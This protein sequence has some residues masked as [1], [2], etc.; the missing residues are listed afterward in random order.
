MN[1]IHLDVYSHD[2]V[3]FN[4]AYDRLISKLPMMKDT[5]GYNVFTI[6]GC[7]PGVGATAI[8]INISVSLA[9][10]N[11]KT[12]LVDADMRKSHSMKRLSSDADIGLSDFL[13]GKASFDDVICLT[14]IDN[15]HFMSSGEFSENPVTLL[16]SERFQEVIRLIGEQYAYVIFDSPALNTTVD[17]SI[18]APKTSG[19]VLVAEYKKTRISKIRS[20]KEE[21]SQGGANVI[22]I[23]L[24]NVAKKDYKRY[25]ENYDYFSKEKFSHQKKAEQKKRQIK[26]SNACDWFK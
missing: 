2:N 21:L 22:G 20:A 26:W 7:E 16:N 9:N 25:V 18:I 23:V 19:V 10:S 13:S 15:L 1:K 5:K 24:N 6:S 8:S 17:A 11:W 4:D 14:N 3:V 12:L